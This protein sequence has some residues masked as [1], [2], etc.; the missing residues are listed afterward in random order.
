[1]APGKR[2]DLLLVAGDPTQ[3]LAALSKIREV[4]ARGVRIER[5]PIAAQPS[6]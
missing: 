2:A 3:D 4:I 1:V 5:I 6:D